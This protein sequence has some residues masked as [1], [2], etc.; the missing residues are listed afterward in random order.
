VQ[1]RPQVPHSPRIQVC[2]ENTSPRWARYCLVTD[3]GTYVNRKVT[4]ISRV[5]PGPDTAIHGAVPGVERVSMDHGVKP[6][7]DEAG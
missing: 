2:L 4:T 7:G 5:F 3:I 1:I 6:G